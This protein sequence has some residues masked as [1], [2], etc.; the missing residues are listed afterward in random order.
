MQLLP[1]LQRREIARF[2]RR[3]DA[4]AYVRVLRQRASGVQ[5]VV[6]FDPV[7]DPSALVIQQPSTSI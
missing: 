3:N 4:D 2:R 1:G 6:V 7:L 5:Y